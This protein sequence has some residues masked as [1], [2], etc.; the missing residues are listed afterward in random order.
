MAK[1]NVLRS[2]G[3][4][5]LEVEVGEHGILTITDIIKT[6]AAGVLN[7][8]DFN[9]DDIEALRKE[10]RKKIIMDEEPQRA[11]RWILQ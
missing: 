9:K 11:S 2:D 4:C 5:E 6:G 8:S 3:G 7:L 10:A 1:K